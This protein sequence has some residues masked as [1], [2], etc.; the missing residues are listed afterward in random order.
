MIRKI[1]EDLQRMKRNFPFSIISNKQ[2]LE[3][4]QEK[5]HEIL[6]SLKIFQVF[7][8]KFLNVSKSPEM[9]GENLEMSGYFFQPFFSIPCKRFYFFQESAIPTISVNIENIFSE[10][11]RVCY[12][13]VGLSDEVLGIFDR[14]GWHHPRQERSRKTETCCNV[15]WSFKKCYKK[16]PRCGDSVH[17]S[18]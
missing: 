9:S 1:Y 12:R 11:K 13:L 2:E 18:L 4:F 3:K 15:S 8:G 17:W 10:S 16:Q 14:A 6:K 7:Y 5:F